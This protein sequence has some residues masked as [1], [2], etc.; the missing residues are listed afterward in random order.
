MPVM[1]LRLSGQC[2]AS[3]KIEF[4]ANFENAHEASIRTAGRFRRFLQIPS[5]SL[6]AHLAGRNSRRA[7][8][9]PLGFFCAVT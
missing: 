1:F 6:F 9:L 8:P 5:L 4:A 7:Y 2:F 3:R